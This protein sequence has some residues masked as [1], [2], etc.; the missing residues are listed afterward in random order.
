[1]PATRRAATRAAACALVRHG[2]TAV[3]DGRE[4][5]RP[6]CGMQRVVVSA[7]DHMRGWMPAGDAG[8]ILKVRYLFVF[9]VFHGELFM[10]T[11]SSLS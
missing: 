1:M 7:R 8:C 5:G 9:S 3:I 2:V 11:P 4:R 10:I 6:V